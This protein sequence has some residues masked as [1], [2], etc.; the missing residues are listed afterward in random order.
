M[1]LLSQ[2]ASVIV[3]TCLLVIIIALTVVTTVAAVGQVI[4]AYKHLWNGW[5]GRKR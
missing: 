2:I 4:S 5:N 3:V 1:E